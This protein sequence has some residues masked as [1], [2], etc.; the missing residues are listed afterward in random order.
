MK[1]VGIQAMSVNCSLGSDFKTIWHN[2]IFDKG[3]SLSKDKHF[4]FNN[5]TYLGNATFNKKH[6]KDFFN[7]R[8]NQLLLNVFSGIETNYRELAKSIDKNRIGIVLGTSTAGVDGFEKALDHYDKNAQWPNEYRIHEQRMGSV[9]EFLADYLQVYGPCMSISTACS[10]STKALL[11]AKRWLNEETAKLNILGG[12]ESSDAYHISS[13]DPSA[14]GAITTM[15]EALNDAAL[16]PEDIDYINLHGTGTPQND[17][18][19]SLAV[20]HVFGEHTACSSTKPFTGHTLGAAGAIE[21]VL[22]AIAMTDVNSQGAL[23]PHI[24]DGCYD[25]RMPTI[26]L[27]DDS[28]ENN[29]NIKERPQKVLSNSFAF[30]GSNATIIL[31]ML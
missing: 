22:S 9:S 27:V 14:E 26:N 3:H 8:V 10:S 4:L 2:M 13:P 19:E 31:G 20:N 12:G 23:I 28:F 11:T 17:A 15:R 18:M 5:E 1:P 7:Y 29:R 21:A 25:Q 6:I 16:N 30:G 24:Y